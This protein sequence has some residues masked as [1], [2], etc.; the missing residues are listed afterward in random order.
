MSDLWMVTVRDRAGQATE[1]LFNGAEGAD[2]T[3][4]RISE[5]IDLQNVADGL[6]APLC[7]LV[8]VADDYGSTITVMSDTIA[9]VWLQS[10]VMVAEGQSEVALFRARANA[11]V[12]ERAEADPMLLKAAAKQRAAQVLHGPGMPFMPGRG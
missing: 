7:A 3:Y 10:L 1:L 4:D 6:I 2:K 12:Q 11:K 9:Q 8:T 5:A